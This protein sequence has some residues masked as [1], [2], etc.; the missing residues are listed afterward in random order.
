MIDKYSIIKPH[1]PQNFSD[2]VDNLILDNWA[3][4]D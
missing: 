3:F 2:R 1:F 4:F